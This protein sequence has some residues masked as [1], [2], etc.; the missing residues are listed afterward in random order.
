MARND[1]QKGK[2][3]FQSEA[4]LPD[5]HTLTQGVVKRL[6]GDKGFGF[7]REPGGTEY[8][9]HQSAV[10]GTEFND[11]REGDAVRFQPSVHHNPKGPRA[12]LVMRDEGVGNY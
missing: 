7:V 9:F 3:P 10:R 12:D 4:P 1:S 5:L 11:L 2:T 6:V 8:F